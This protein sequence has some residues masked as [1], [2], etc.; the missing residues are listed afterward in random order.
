MVTPTKA[1]ALRRAN[2]F[3]MDITHSRPETH[4]GDRSNIETK[5]GHDH[6]PHNRKRKTFKT[7]N[8][9]GNNCKK[10]IFSNIKNDRKQ[11]LKLMQK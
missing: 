5:M 7:N 9:L 8:R 6:K 3:Q 10:Y 4:T 2:T 11:I 1:N